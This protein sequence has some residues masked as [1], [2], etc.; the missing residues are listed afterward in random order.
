MLA[1]VELVRDLAVAP[2]DGPV[3]SVHLRTDPRDPANTNHVP[4]WLITLRNGLRAVAERVERSDSRDERMVLRDLMPRVETDIADLTPAERG[5]A[6]SYFIG[7]DGSGKLFLAHQIPLRDDAVRWD[8]RPFISPLV[9]I[10]SRGRSTGLVLIGVDAVRL[11]HWHA[12]RIDEPERSVY[13]LELGDWREYAGYAAANPAR[14]QQ[15]ATHTEAYEDRVGD[16]RRRFLAGTAQKV[17]QR[18]REFGWRRLIVAGELPLPG[19]FVAGLDADVS[20]RV[21][22]QIDANVVGQPPAEVAARLED[23]LERAH[24]AQAHALLH[25][26]AAAAAAGTVGAL[27][28]EEVFQALAEHRVDHLLVDPTARLH[29]GP[30][31]AASQ[32][33]VEGAGQD[34]LAE[35]AVELAVAGGAEVTTLAAGEASEFRDASGLAAL[36]RY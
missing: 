3:L 15:T 14:G 9:D 27:G 6:I 12:G 36:L 29:L 34:L 28:P 30:L 19:D 5:R 35:R 13:E 10:A 8:A 26:I 11:L 16:W 24:R 33:A 22:T 32:Q 23:D 18:A 25:R 17:S 31:G 2:S 7:A 1:T 20:A 4:G 21:V